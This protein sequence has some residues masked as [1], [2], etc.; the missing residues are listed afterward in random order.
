M[1]ISIRSH[2]I[3]G[4]AAV[5]GASAIAMTPVTA[6]NLHLP[7]V[8]VPSVAQVALTGLDSPITEMLNT[9]SYVNFDLFNGNPTYADTNYSWE[10]YGGMLPEF[11]YTALPILTQMGYN[12]AANINNTLADLNTAAIILSEAV[13]N[14]PGVVITAAK[15]LFNGQFQ[16]AVATLVNGT[17]VPLKDA[18]ATAITAG[19]AVISNVT[20]NLT[21]VLKT[22]PGI[23]TGMVNSAI[24]TV[25]LAINSV[26][27]ITKLTF[28][29]L[30]NKDYEGAWNSVV[31]G[32]FGPV[33][34]DGSVLSSLPGVLESMTIG[35]GVGPLGFHN[36]YTYP[37]LRMT[38][39]Q[40]QL[41]IANALGSN[42]PAA[43]VAPKAS[44]RSAAA[45]RKA[46]SVAAV[47]AAPAA[48]ATAGDNSSADA[49][50]PS[51]GAEKAGATSGRS[52]GV[53][54]AGKH[55][56]SRKSARAAA[57]N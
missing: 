47:T 22:L 19:A 17:W 3:A 55:N 28:A 56:A 14:L 15:E 20:T 52:A 42:W 27:N 36:G 9:L 49:T 39:E 45:S 41:Q 2:L 18:A 46:A 12:G 25:K 24:A 54:K 7:T 10:P 50:T 21:A 38:G 16:D 44:A 26:V 35:P 4:T 57:A 48:A 13:W 51:V 37:S 33:G 11:I 1:Q 53:A 40:S 6:A 29:A 30:K 31:D 43:S 8:K 5:V 23:A 34:S 32:L